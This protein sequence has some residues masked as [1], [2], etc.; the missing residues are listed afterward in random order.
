MK[1][2]LFLACLLLSWFAPAQR[3]SPPPKTSASGSYKLLEVRATGSVRYNDQQIL[4]ASGLRLGQTAAE[5]DFREAAQHLLNSGMF[6]DVAYTFSYS[7][8][9]IRV[10]FQLTDGDKAKLVPAHFENFVGFT[11]SELHAS[12]EEHVPLFTGLLPITGQLTDQVTHALQA[13]LDERHLPGQ[14]DHAREGEHDDSPP[15]G[16]TF[17][18]LGLSIRIHT[19]EFPGATRDQAAFL[20]HATRR[21]L[22]SEY[23]D[24]LTKTAIHDDLLPLYL[25]RGYLKASFGS[26]ETRVVSSPAAPTTGHSS[27]EIQVDAILPVT[28]GKQYAFTGA[29]WKGNSA[30]TTKEASSLF[31]LVIGQPADAT[32]LEHD[33]QTL[34][35]LYRSRGYMTV[36]IKAVPWIDEAAAAVHYDINIVE[37]DLYTMGELEFLGADTASKDRLTEAWKLREGQPYNPDYTRKFLDD[38]PHFLPKGLQYSIKLSEELDAKARTVDVTIH[39]RPD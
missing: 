39:F 11:D 26:P 24:S 25:E 4:R 2:S 20:E 13:L 33:L 30:I 31:H 15:T 3:R 14:V 35:S 9:G 23:S 27:D 12:L 28:P 22:G 32:G 34:T 19:L 29:D 18:V 8:A 36:K 1:R 37:G 16:I 17:R 6:T 7:D 10:E 5:G 21:L 38:A